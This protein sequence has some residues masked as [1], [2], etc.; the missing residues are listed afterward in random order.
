M[1]RYP[2]THY[3]CLAEEMGGKGERGQHNDDLPSHTEISRSK[4][5]DIKVIR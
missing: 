1:G 5:D 3:V 2:H 4:L